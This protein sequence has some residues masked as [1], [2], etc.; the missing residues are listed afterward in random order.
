MPA[1]G[2]AFF[3]PGPHKPSACHEKMQMEPPSVTAA[4]TLCNTSSRTRAN[5]A[6]C[7]AACCLRVPPSPP[8]PA[9][10]A[11]NPTAQPTQIMP[12]PNA[13]NQPQCRMKCRASEIG[14]RYNAHST[15]YLGPIPDF[16]IRSTNKM[17]HPSV[18]SF[19]VLRLGLGV[20]FAWAA[21]RQKF[22][23]SF[24]AATNL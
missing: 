23:C 20:S 2:S 14:P 12:H 15:R 9:I 24:N 22:S 21:D 10:S 13:L 8:S 3:T 1:V 5:I 18:S 7:S 6:K 4:P 11:H 17:A 16:S 19:L